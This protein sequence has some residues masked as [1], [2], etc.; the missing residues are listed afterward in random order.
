MH[1]LFN[2]GF[3]SFSFFIYDDQIVSSSGVESF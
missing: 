3:F 2:V 1:R